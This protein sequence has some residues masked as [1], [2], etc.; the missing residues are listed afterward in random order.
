[1]LYNPSDSAHFGQKTHRD[2][3]DGKVYVSDVVD[4]FVPIARDKQMS[5]SWLTTLWI[6]RFIKQVCSVFSP[7]SE[8]TDEVRVSQSQ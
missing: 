5:E 8:S 6:G 1:M 7:K 3:V 4:W 2:A